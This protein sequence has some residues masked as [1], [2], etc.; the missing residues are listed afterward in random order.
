M[1]ELLKRKS[2]KIALFAIT[3]IVVAGIAGINVQSA[4][5]DMEYNRHMDAAERYLSELDYEQAIAEY[6][7]ALEIES[8]EEVLDALEKTYLAY[9][10]AVVDK[11]DLERAI[12]ILQEGYAVTGR[13]SLKEKISELE[14][15]AKA[16][17]SG[18]A[19]DETMR[20]IIEIPF[21]VSDITIKGYDL[22][23]D[24]YNEIIGAYGCPPPGVENGYTLS[25]SLDGDG[26][27]FYSEGVNCRIWEDHKELNV[28]PP[29][30][31]S[32]M[33]YQ[34]WLHENN[35]QCSLELWCEPSGS[36]ADYGVNLPVDLQRSYDDWCQ[37][38]QVG[39]IKE[40]G[41]K[42]AIEPGSF[43]EGGEKWNFQTK[44]GQGEYF[45]FPMVNG[46]SQQR[47]VLDGN[48]DGSWYQFTIYRLEEGNVSYLIGVVVLY[49]YE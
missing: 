15:A 12:A 37:V 23:S 10:Q 22:L 36:W 8:K 29:A 41:E 33:S 42:I 20:G 26:L 4:Q 34:V 21:E 25:A 1:K 9:A 5:K 38:M 31:A 28:Q 6:I 19:E 32:R 13:E 14:D 35:G 40:A 39:K 18:D 43:G 47:L 49:G 45:E 7:L 11:G 44:W 2:V 30:G 16:P 3:L 17:E 46:G 27:R 48:K 24:H